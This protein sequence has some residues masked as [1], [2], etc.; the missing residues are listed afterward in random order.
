[1]DIKKEIKKFETHKEHFKNVLIDEIVLLAQS[2]CRKY[3]KVI[4]SFHLEDDNIYFWFDYV[5]E[6]E[7]GS[8]RITTANN[9]DNS[10]D[11]DLIEEFGIDENQA[12]VQ[13]YGLYQNYGDIIK[14]ETIVLERDNDFNE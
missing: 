13:L 8:I 14:E 9:I 1:M 11:W 12:F 7:Y 5:S 2:I 10:N 4:D 3:K 6:D